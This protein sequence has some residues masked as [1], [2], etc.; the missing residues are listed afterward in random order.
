MKWLTPIYGTSFFFW[1]FF[2]RTIALCL[3]DSFDQ[4][5]SEHSDGSFNVTTATQFLRKLIG[6][7]FYFGKLI[8]RFLC[9]WKLLNYPRQWQ[10]V[11][12]T[13]F[14]ISHSTDRRLWGFAAEVRCILLHLPTRELYAF[15][16]SSLDSVTKL[17]PKVENFSF[18]AEGSLF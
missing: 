5:V 13:Q 10:Y 18:C 8:W 17:L 15:R 1:Y 16:I 7:S 14:Q 12:L 9:E 11:T 3:S 6:V 2:T 4:K